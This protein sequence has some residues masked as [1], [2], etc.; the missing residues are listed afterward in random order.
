M[1]PTLLLIDAMNIIARNHGAIARDES[2]S[3]QEVAERTLNGSLGTIF[4]TL[5]LLEPTH[6]AA[7]F[8]GAGNWREAV[9]PD[10]KAKRPEKKASLRMGADLVRDRL[11]E[12]AMIRTLHQDGFEAD[13]VIA[14]IGI[15]AASAGVRVVVLTTDKDAWQLMASGIEVF[16][17]FERVF[18]DRE[19]VLN[20][21]K[22][23]VEPSQVAD[24]LAL[25][26]DGSDGVPGVP[27]VGAKTAAK[28]LKQYGNLEGVLANAKAVTGKVGEQLREHQE[29]ARLCYK[30][31]QLGIRDEIQLQVNL[32]DL[33]AP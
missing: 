24:S 2:L 19:Y 18:R 30:M 28:W 22:M 29:Q 1:R 10:Y 16:D 7:V 15:K 26:G 5:H 31:V 4:K 14:N 13:D 8:E 32:S 9:F 20:H 12:V 21:P 25:Q 17:P 6:V 33:I 27:G 3:D 11:E 23:G